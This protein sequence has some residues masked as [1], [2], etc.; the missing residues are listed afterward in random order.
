MVVKVEGRG[1]WVLGLASIRRRLHPCLIP[2]PLAPVFWASSGSLTSSILRGVA[3]TNKRT[4][5]RKITSKACKTNIG[6]QSI[7]DGLVLLGDGL[8]Y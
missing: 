6:N 8:V 1:R 4:Q 7:L 5:T 3:S 2:V